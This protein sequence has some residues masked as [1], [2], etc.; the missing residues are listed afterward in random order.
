MRT[1]IFTIALSALI[2]V[3]SCKNN[4]SG[5][6]TAPRPVKICRAVPADG[7]SQLVF[8]GK[9]ISDDKVYTAFKVAGRIASLNVKE[10]DTVRAG[11]TIGY[12]DDT[13]YR[14]A[15]EATEAEYNSIRSEAERIIAL[16]N[17][18]ATTAAAHDKA[19]YGLQ[20]ITAK[21]Q[22]ARNQLND[23]R[24]TAPSSGVVKTILRHSG[25]VVGAGTP[26]LEIVDNNAPLV[27]IKIPAAAFGRLNEYTG[28]TCTFDAYPGETFRLR[29]FAEQSVANANQLYTVKLSF[30]DNVTPMP[31]VGMSATVVMHREDT[32]T[33][34]NT[35]LWTVPSTALAGDENASYIFTVAPDST[36]RRTPVEVVRLTRDGE[37]E[38]SCG[39]S[40]EAT[41]IVAAGAGKMR[42]NMKISPIA[43]PAATNVGNQ[44]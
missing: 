12:L 4:D 20:Q 6:Q 2:A 31:S 27:E 5:E 44:L 14:V 43:P 34:D 16:Y 25:E 42:E 29:P 13:D 1:N 40:L 33:A 11:Q 26:V 15:L 36:L 28:F 3:S 7:G 41:D 23:T 38:I 32:P 35:G 30:A 19:V 9:V 10:G 21:L 18:N 37:A 17:E 39:I 8:P 24:L 22:H